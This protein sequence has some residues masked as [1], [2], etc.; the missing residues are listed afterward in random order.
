M[1]AS[2]LTYLTYSSSSIALLAP[3]NLGA[4]EPKIV[5][6]PFTSK[7]YAAAPLIRPTPYY[8]T[9]HYLDT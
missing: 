7:S 9:L 2:S 8:T 5:S 4:N 6:Y 3:S 1:F